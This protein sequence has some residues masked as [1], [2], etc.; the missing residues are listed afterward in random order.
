MRT[1]GPVHGLPVPCASSASSARGPLLQLPVRRTRRC[2]GRCPTR[3]RPT[4][5]NELH[6]LAWGGGSATLTR[7]CSTSD[8]RCLPPTATAR[9]TIDASRRRLEPEVDVTTDRRAFRAPRP[10]PGL[11]GWV[12]YRARAAGRTGRRTSPRS[13]TTADRDEAGRAVRFLLR[14]STDAAPHR[15]HRDRRRRLR[16]RPASSSPT[17][18]GRGERGA[19]PRPGRA[20]TVRADPGRSTTRGPRR[21][22]PRRSPSTSPSAEAGEVVAWP[23]GLRRR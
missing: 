7:R 5:W 2:C 13:A 15:G 14:G 6:R 3:P 23:G 4:R 22:V 8:P 16:L 1:W 10:H 12:Q 9:S 11:P 18:S 19:R 17:T 21:V 20:G